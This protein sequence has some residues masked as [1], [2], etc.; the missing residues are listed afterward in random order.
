MNKFII[1]KPTRLTL[2]D[3]II[4]YLHSDVIISTIWAVADMVRLRRLATGKPSIKQLALQYSKESAL[5][6]ADC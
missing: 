3:V 6:A 1:T 4:Y 2:R 5:I